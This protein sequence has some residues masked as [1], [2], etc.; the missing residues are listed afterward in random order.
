MR[1]ALN[2]SAAKRCCAKVE[3]MGA[4]GYA[5]TALVP[6]S[7]PVISG[8]QAGDLGGIMHCLRPCL[9]GHVTVRGLGS[10]WQ[11][12]H[13]STVMAAW[14]APPHRWKPRAM[15]C[16]QCTA[17]KTLFDVFF[18]F[19]LLSLSP[20]LERGK[21]LMFEKQLSHGGACERKQ[22]RPPES[23]PLCG[24]LISSTDIKALTLTSNCISSCEASSL[25][26][27][28]SPPYSFSSHLVC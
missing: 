19:F 4:Q 6:V 23:N 9:S 24:H 20:A 5:P 25:L 1:G 18:F 17:L 16:T 15:W 14:A 10:A 22:H 21:I 28:P 27:L 12:G 7:S 13:I 2:H 11:P 3:N 8:V 26:S